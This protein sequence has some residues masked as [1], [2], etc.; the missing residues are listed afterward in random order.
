M[1]AV[2]GNVERTGEFEDDGPELSGSS[3]GQLLGLGALKNGPPPLANTHASLSR[4]HWVRAAVEQFLAQ[5]TFRHEWDGQTLQLRLTKSPRTDGDPRKPRPVFPQDALPWSRGG[6][7]VHT[8][9]VWSLDN[10]KMDCPVFDLPA[11]ASVV[12]GTCPGATAGQ[13]IVPE[14]PR[15]AAEQRLVQMG[16]P[17]LDL[18]AGALKQTSV[19]SDPQRSICQSCVPGDTLLM[20]QGEGLRRIDEMLGRRFKVWSGVDWR[21]TQVVEQGMKP[22]FLLETRNGITLRATADHRVSTTDGWVEVQDLQQ[23][24]AL[25][26][27]LPPTAPFPREA[28][29][30]LRD[31][32]LGPA[33]RTEK[34]GELPAEWSFEL[35]VLLGYMVGDGSFY[36]ATKYPTASLVAAEH[37]ADDLRRLAKVVS[38]W[39][40]SESEVLIRRADPSGMVETSS[41]HAHLHW[42]VKGL[43]HLFTQL[44]LE[45]R[46]THTTTPRGI[47][48]A[49]ERGVAG[50]LSGLFSTDG[51]VG[52]SSGA[53]EISFTNTS[54]PLI[55]EVQQ[56]LMAFGIQTS[57]TEYRS[58][59]E[60]G[61]SPLWKLGIKSIDS[62]R[63]FAEVIGFFNERKSKLLNEA[64]AAQAHRQGRTT[65]MVV[66]AVTPTRKVEAVYDLLN[67]GDEHQFLA[68]GLVIH[69]CYAE[70]GSYAYADNAARLTL[71]YW[72]A[73]GMVS[74][75]YDAFVDAM[76]ESILKLSFPANAPGNILPIRLHSS[77]DF[78]STRYAQAWMDIA[79][80][81]HTAGGDVGKRVRF[82]AP[83]RTW[84]TTGWDEFWREQL[85]KMKADN[86]MV[87]ASAFNF[88]DPA[89]GALSPGNALG[90]SSL[91]M[92]SKEE[93]LGRKDFRA[94]AAEKTHFD[95]MC[96]T[97]AQVDKSQLQLKSCTSSPNP[98]GGS[99]CRACWVAPKMRI[100]YPAH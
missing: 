93:A 79:D 59:A 72:W 77:G 95:W 74:N 61:Y 46:G 10:S 60:R 9:K 40:G 14:G 68:N 23:G 29:T 98:F 19:P 99:H 58:N 62:V 100:N 4:T 88:D 2:T 83:T 65:R 53:V 5:C 91:Y 92:Q 66:D 11:G 13:S 25:P 90:S 45:K 84:A 41:P 94:T 73:V 44:G 17:S 80:K 63:R 56:L 48:S 75:H 52:V 50:Y 24:D 16:A 18:P 31:A 85:P 28:S 64:F 96:P 97:Y 78:F 7:V 67:V 86:F 54:R 15:R 81:L 82:W 42:R 43:T 1:A 47:W 30:H 36:T 35:G 8:V 49:S 12:G 55:E 3:L 38:A 69:N 71:R 32:D 51:S 6:S 76:F 37:D 39:T 22:T 89:P 33:Y 70:G 21:E 87:R 27:A 34:R 20:V 57:F 26:Y